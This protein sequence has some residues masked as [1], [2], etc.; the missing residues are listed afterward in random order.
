[1][2]GFFLKNRIGNDLGL[3]GIGNGNDLGRIPIKFH[4]TTF[5]S[6]LFYI[7]IF[8]IIQK[9]EAQV[10]RSLEVAHEAQLHKAQATSPAGHGQTLPP[11]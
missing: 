8:E 1:M 3:V 6:E 9:S 10:T 2:V 11:V 7:T 5:S 4:I